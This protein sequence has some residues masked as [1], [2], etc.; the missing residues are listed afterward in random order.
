[1]KKFSR[2]HSLS[3]SSLLTRSAIPTHSST[4]THTSK[5]KRLWFAAKKYGWGWYPVTWE[6]WALL[7][8]YLSAIFAD[9]WR[10]NLTAPFANSAPPLNFLIDTLL[11]TFLFLVICFLTGE[12]PRWRWGDTKKK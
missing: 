11:L 9:Y 10:V 1:M 4:P 2:S 5:K 3:H 8:I 7:V 12:E 6:G